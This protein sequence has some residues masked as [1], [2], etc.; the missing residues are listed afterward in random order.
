[1]PIRGFKLRAGT[2]AGAGGLHQSGRRFRLSPAVVSVMVR[3]LG[4]NM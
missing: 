4:N 2:I 3:R 1:M